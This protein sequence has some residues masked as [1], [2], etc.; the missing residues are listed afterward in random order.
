MQTLKAIVGEYTYEIQKKNGHL[1]LP[2]MVNG[3]IICTIKKSGHCGKEF[4]DDCMIDLEKIILQNQYHK[5]KQ[6]KNRIVKILTTLVSVVF[7]I[8][9]PI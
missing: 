8:V 7:L 1:V 6:K 5:L 2:D 3:E 4:C 9:V